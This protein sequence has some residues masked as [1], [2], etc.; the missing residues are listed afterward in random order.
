MFSDFTNCNESLKFAKFFYLGLAEK[1][2]DEDGAKNDG[3][4]ILNQE[5]DNLDDSRISLAEPESARKEEPGS[6]EV[7]ATSDKIANEE[8]ESE[9]QDEK[10]E[11]NSVDDPKEMQP[12]NNQ[13][14]NAETA[15][16]NDESVVESDGPKTEEAE[17][18]EVTPVVEPNEESADN[19]AS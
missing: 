18:Q 11:T 1:P 9:K 17:K 3:T 8:N 10:S 2:A 5:A 4:G 13:L 19:I 6:V 7:V 16:D 12:V 14:E 15:D